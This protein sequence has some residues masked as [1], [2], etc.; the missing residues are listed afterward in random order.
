MKKNYKYQVNEK[1]IIVEKG[2]IKQIDVDKIFYI[3]SEGGMSS[4]R[5]V[6]QKNV[7]V[8][9]SL[10]YFEK[11][12]NSLGFIRAN[13]NELINCFKIRE[14]IPKQKLIILENLEEISISFRQ[15]SMFRKFFTN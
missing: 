10:N 15:I 8:I 14:F 12:L 4:I 7:N 5:L 13:R 9:K 1:L 2:K 11:E 6:E 3:S